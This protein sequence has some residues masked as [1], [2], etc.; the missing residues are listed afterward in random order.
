MNKFSIVAR[1]LDVGVHATHSG[2]V[3]E[4]DLHDIAL[5]HISLEVLLASYVLARLAAELVKLLIHGWKALQEHR[6]K[7]RAGNAEAAEQ[8]VVAD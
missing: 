6:A 7:R 8:A 2:M 1:T 5:G 3:I 4:H